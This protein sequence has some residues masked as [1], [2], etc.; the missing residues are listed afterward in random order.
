MAAQ[1]EALEKLLAAGRDNALLRF[2]LGSAYLAQDE[3][4]AAIMHLR[5]AVAS[6][7][8]YSA[9]WKTL[10]HAY[11]KAGR[12]VEALQAY[13]SGMAAA[14]KKGDKQ[15]LKEMQV[16]ARRIEKQLANQ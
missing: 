12:N 14:Q 2:G 7:A 11:A 1:I 3:Y 13:N 9:A 15:A 6:D 10:G 4:E 16:F 8:V 5:C